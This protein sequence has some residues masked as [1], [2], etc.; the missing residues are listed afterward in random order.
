MRFSRIS[1]LFNA[2]SLATAWPTLNSFGRNS[3]IPGLEGFA[4]DNPMGP[5]TGGKGAKPITVTNVDELLSAVQG[6]T[7]KII[8]LDGEFEPSGRLRVGSHTTLLGKGKGANIVGEGISIVN[9][10]NIIIR[11]IGIRFVEGDDGMALQNST[12]VWVDHCDFESRI[13][14]ELGPDYYVS[15]YAI[16][17]ERMKLMK[18]VLRYRMDNSTSSAQA[19]GSPSPTT[20]STTTGKYPS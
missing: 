16:R 4:L 12:R 8:Y 15:E 2:F 20:T 17:Q 7:P 19:T 18:L 1:A 3:K 5:T 10:T 13:S 9:A 6:D 11:N 14:V